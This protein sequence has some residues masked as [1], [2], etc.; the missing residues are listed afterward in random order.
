MLENSLKTLFEPVDIVVDKMLL[1]DF[2]FIDQTHQSKT[3]VHFS[4]VEHDVFRRIW[5]P[6]FDEWTWLLVERG[7]NSFLI[8]S[9]DA[10]NVNQNVNQLWAN[11]VVRHVDWRWIRSYVNLCDYIEEECFLYVGFRY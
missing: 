1:V 8:L 6:Q 2:R 10:G 4:Q 11:F 5:M 9:V 7:A 3:R